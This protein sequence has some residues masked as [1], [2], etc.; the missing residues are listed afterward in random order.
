MGN[1]WRDKEGNER[2]G[3]RDR[4]QVHGMA[5]WVIMR[6]QSPKKY[7]SP[8]MYY[9]ST[10]DSFSNLY[11][12][13]EYPWRGRYEVMYPLICKEFVRGKLQ[14]THF[15]LSH[16]LIDTVIPL[17]LAFQRLSK[18][19]QLAAQQATRA[20]EERAATQ[21]IADMLLDKLP[22]FWGPVSFGGQGIRTSLLDRKMA[23][24]QKVWDRFSRAGLKPLFSRGM[25]QS[26][27]NRPKPV[28]YK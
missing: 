7:G 17:I 10:Y 21:E 28:D 2:R 23:Q 5:C 13:G 15:P 25:S 16:F 12:T 11:I 4:Y 20:A 19:E 22:S 3:Y 24:I 6:W 26:A 18:E 1:V 27:T 9:A 14:V 8:R